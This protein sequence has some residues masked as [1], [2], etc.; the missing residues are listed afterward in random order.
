MILNVKAEKSFDEMI[1]LH[2]MALGS[3]QQNIHGWSKDPDDVWRYHFDL[4]R[5]TDLTFDMSLGL[6]RSSSSDNFIDAKVYV[7][8]SHPTDPTGHWVISEETIFT[9]LDWTAAGAS[10]NFS[11]NHLVQVTIPHQLFTSGNFPENYRI[12][13]IIEGKR[14]TDNFASYKNYFQERYH[15][16][17]LKPIIK[18]ASS[19]CNEEM[20]RISYASSVALENATG[21]ANLTDMG[22]GSY[23]ISRTGSATGS[24]T[25]VAYDKNSN[26]IEKGVFLGINL[27]RYL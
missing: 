13:V 19:I 16:Y 18:G 11:R 17:I 3:N 2:S 9:P 21:L 24:A 10:G 27:Y 12:S 15:E 1:S 5:T 6:K 22:G 8:L 26:R 23:K 25:I 7:V 14:L 20:Y 4:N